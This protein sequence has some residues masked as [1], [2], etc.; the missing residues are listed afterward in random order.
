M[1]AQRHTTIEVA[2]AIFG[3]MPRAELH[4]HK[5]AIPGFRIAN[6]RESFWRTSV[7]LSGYDGYDAC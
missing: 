2:R 7:K 6:R 1:M 5:P 3:V 4:K